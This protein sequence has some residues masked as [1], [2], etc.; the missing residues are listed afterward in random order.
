M[1]IELNS[2]VNSTPQTINDFISI[3][4]GYEDA[5][6]NETYMKKYG[7][8]V[9]LQCCLKMTG[10]AFP[11]VPATLSKYPPMFSLKTYG[12]L[13]DTQW[14]IPVAVLYCHIGNE[15]II[16]VAKNYTEDVKNK[17]INI[18]AVYLTS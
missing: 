8:V 14:G 12:Y 13:A 3:Q 17:F 9:M 4:D 1:T 15:G 18:Y 16:H 10:N 2:E 6:G 11:S 7:K 5:G